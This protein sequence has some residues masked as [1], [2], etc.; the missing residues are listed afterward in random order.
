MFFPLLSLLELESNWIVHTFFLSLYLTFIG[1]KG[2]WIQ[3][4]KIHKHS[5][6]NYN[7]GSEI[8]MYVC[9]YLFVYIL[10]LCIYF[11]LQIDTL[12]AEYPSVTNYLYVTYNGQV[13]TAK[14]L[15]IESSRF[16]KWSTWGNIY[17]V[18]LWFSSDLDNKTDIMWVKYD[19]V[20][21]CS[22]F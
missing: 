19:N 20:F 2:I 22:D 6:K 3:N 16:N 17:F 21:L 4:K 12:A 13:G 5:W 18:Y 10:Y 11:L 9:V 1:I 8:L 7:K 14:H 15:F